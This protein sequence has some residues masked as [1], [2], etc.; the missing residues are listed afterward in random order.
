[1]SCTRSLYENCIH[2]LSCFP[3]GYLPSRN[4]QLSF[5]L[6]RDRGTV[7]SFFSGIKDVCILFRSVTFLLRIMQ[8][9][10][11]SVPTYRLLCVAHEGGGTLY[12]PKIFRPLKELEGWFFSMLF[13]YFISP[14]S[15]RNFWNRL[16]NEASG[17]K[18]AFEDFFGQNFPK[19]LFL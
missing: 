10:T 4:H 6:S 13:I 7:R 17:H 19:I 12:H 2:L 11:L 3:L 9:L 16:K 15:K 14:T 18:N 5:L 1:M 8:R